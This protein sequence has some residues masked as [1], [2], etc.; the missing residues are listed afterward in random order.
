MPFRSSYLRSDTKGGGT[1]ADAHRYTLLF[2]HAQ[3]RQQFITLLPLRAHSARPL[4]NKA[5]TV[6]EIFGDGGE[7]VHRQDLQSFTLSFLGI[8][9]SYGTNLFL[10]T[11]MLKAWIHQACHRLY[12][13]EWMWQTPTGEQKLVWEI[14]DPIRVSD[15]NGQ[16]KRICRFTVKVAPPH[17]LAPTPEELFSKGYE[18][19]L[20]NADGNI[21]TVQ[22]MKP[23]V[24]QRPDGIVPGTIVLHP[25]PSAPLREVKVMWQGPPIQRL[26]ATTD[27][28]PVTKSMPALTSWR[29]ELQYVAAIIDDLSARDP[30]LKFTLCEQ[31]VTAR[32][33]AGAQL[34]DRTAQ[35]LATLDFGSPQLTART[36]RDVINTIGEAVQAPPATPPKAQSW[37]PEQIDAGSAIAARLQPLHPEH[38]PGIVAYLLSTAS[39]QE[40]PLLPALDDTALNQRVAAAQLQIQANNQ[41]SGRPTLNAAIQQATQG[42]HDLLPTPATAGGKYAAECGQAAWTNALNGMASAIQLKPLEETILLTGEIVTTAVV[43]QQLALKYSM[44][45]PPAQDLEQ[46]ITNFTAVVH[47]EFND[48]CFLKHAAAADKAIA[49]RNGHPSTSAPPVL[50]RQMVKVGKDL[51]LQCFGQTPQ[52]ARVIAVAEAVDGKMTDEEVRR[53][54]LD[55]STVDQSQSTSIWPTVFIRTASTGQLYTSLQH[56]AQPG[57]ISHAVIT[58]KREA[59][60]QKLSAT[61][62]ARENKAQQRLLDSQRVSQFR[63]S[64]KSAI[65]QSIA[66]FITVQPWCHLQ[67]IDEDLLDDH[68]ASIHVGNLPDVIGTATVNQHANTVAN[69]VAAARLELDEQTARRK[70]A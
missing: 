41:R 57:A 19:P 4:H 34:V 20:M 8:H 59:A 2:Q 69:E 16:D 25:S 70:E 13:A 12:Q 14:S 67:D 1:P 21:S 24:P 38:F 55:P 31:V 6:F 39:A 26:L 54:Q 60:Q 10:S 45:P 35:L 32:K 56:L 68:I 64:V 61:T 46:L 65:Q 37:T 29:F 52:F 7:S 30:T 36:A 42:L 9:E 62:A 43:L 15:G 48:A 44:A 47:T 58:A 27:T 11:E 49:E 66:L 5:G 33:L 50:S 18:L 63:N 51:E 53:L 40:L 3:H 28:A 17:L 23:T 22:P